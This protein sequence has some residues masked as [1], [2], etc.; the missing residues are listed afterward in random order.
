[1]AQIGNSVISNTATVFRNLQI[2]SLNGSVVGESPRFTDTTY[3]SK[4]A[5]DG[6]TQ[7]SLV[8]T[9]EKYDWNNKTGLKIGTTSTT[10]AAGNHTHGTSI[11][12]SSGTNQISLAAN[13]KYAIS[14]G[15]TSFVFT[16][17]AD[18]NTWRPVGTGATDAAAGNH[19]HGLTI[20]TDSGT[21]QLTMT[22]NTKYKLIAGG[23][24]FIFTTPVD[25]NTTYDSKTAA[26]GGTAVSLC[27]TGEK[28]TW[29]SKAAGDH[30]HTLTIAADSGTS[31]LSMSANT[32]YKLTAGGKSFIFTTPENDDTLNGTD[33]LNIL[34]L[35]TDEL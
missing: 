5:V 24:T 6:G 33:S 32:K 19:T 10:A 28:Y 16:T 35:T 14:A 20:S 22:A 1:M 13:T 23:Q 4:A 29:N 7:V 9:G 31:S 3:E 11:A 25:N 8:T 17:P 30:T 34:L 21:S 26:S 27:T 2:T 12:A 18:T 15:G